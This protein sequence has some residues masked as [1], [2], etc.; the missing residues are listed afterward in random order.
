MISAF[1]KF[2][3]I[4]SSDRAVIE[5]Y[6][7]RYRPYADFNFTN[8]WAWDT[9]EE[10]RVS[11]LNGNLVVRFTDYLTGESFLSFLGSRKCTDTAR[12]L[13]DFA[14]ISSISPVL[15][16]VT[17]ESLPELQ[18]STL[19]VNEDKDSFDYI[20]SVSRLANSRSAKL[21]PKHRRA[22]K[23]L[24]QH[25]DARF[26]FRKLDDKTMQKQ[27]MSVLR[28]WE[29]GKKKEN[30]VYNLEYEARAITR[31]LENADGL[32]RGTK[33][34]LSCVFLNDNMVGF[35]IDEI[36]QHNYAISHFIKADTAYKG[37]YE[38]LNEK[39]AAYLEANSV[40]F[41]NWQQDLGI[42]GLR[43]AKKSYDPVDFLKKYT[44]SGT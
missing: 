18:T 41:W 44:V 19:V 4:K 34:F 27:I 23:F 39:I 9:K 30:K 16:F 31:L 3:K 26:E 17:E 37:I 12:K 28:K 10:Q 5:K 8:L 20:Y 14:K 15:R 13:L 1:P 32:M 33:L 36:A 35:G 2:Q 40:E 11:I 38:F 7:A 43:D 25:P 42:G 22:N 21:K 24:L 29:D 6:T